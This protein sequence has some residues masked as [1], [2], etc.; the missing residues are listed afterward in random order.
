M[1]TLARGL[2][3]LLN[4]TINAP[5]QHVKSMCFL[6]SCASQHRGLFGVLSTSSGAFK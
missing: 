2:L 5:S 3:E 6:L 4:L 1:R